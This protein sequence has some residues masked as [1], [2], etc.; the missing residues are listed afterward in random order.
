MGVQIKEHFKDFIALM[1][2][3]FRERPWTRWVALC[4][5]LLFVLWIAWLLRPI[6][7][8]KTVDR[9][10]SYLEKGQCDKAFR[11]ISQRRR[12]DDL[13]YESLE[14]FNDT[15]C[16]RVDK[17]FDKLFVQTGG[18]SLTSEGRD[19]KYSFCL[20]SRAG[21]QTRRVCAQHQALLIKEKYHWK[22]YAL[23]IGPWEEHCHYQREKPETLINPRST[24]K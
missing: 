9:Y 12:D 6:P 19:L 18:D 15:V 10:I 4:L 14:E 11:F 5:A 20:C 7:P 24:T 21:G 16:R 23:E 13:D 3:L 17:E 22:I 2:T 8:R 1:R